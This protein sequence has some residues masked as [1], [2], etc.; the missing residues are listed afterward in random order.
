MQCGA[1]IDKM[2]EKLHELDKLL[3]VESHGN[4]KNE[5]FVGIKVIWSSITVIIEQ[6]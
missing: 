5:K 1:E 6:L 2:A 4:E 3:F